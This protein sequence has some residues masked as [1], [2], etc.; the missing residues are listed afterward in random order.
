[1]KTQNDLRKKAV[2]RLKDENAEDPFFSYKPQEPGDINLLATASFRFSPP[3]WANFN[4]ASN[5]NLGSKPSPSIRNELKQ[6]AKE[7]KPNERKP[8]TVTLN[9]FP[10]ENEY[11][12]SNHFD[13]PG[14]NASRY[15]PEENSVKPKKLKPNKMV[16]H[17]NLFPAPADE[18]EKKRRVGN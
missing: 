4:S 10:M 14:I 6:S 1:M 16:I 11:A 18:Y 2:N 12:A 9:V 13:F 17:L 3:A 7:R 8:L 15:V 5:F